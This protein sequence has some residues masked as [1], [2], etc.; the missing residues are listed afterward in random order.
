MNVVKV[1]AIAVNMVDFGSMTSTFE[2]CSTVT[3]TCCTVQKCMCMPKCMHD[4][5]AI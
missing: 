5:H 4:V 1:D 2:Y 3:E